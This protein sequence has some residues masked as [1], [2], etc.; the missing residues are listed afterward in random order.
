[1]LE[2]ENNTNLLL[3]TQAELR[4]HVAGRISNTAFLALEG[5]GITAPN[6]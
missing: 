1:M 3:S 5:Q 2:I 4:K 6:R